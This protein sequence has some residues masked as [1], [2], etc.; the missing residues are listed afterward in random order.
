MKGMQDTM[1]E[2][3]YQMPDTGYRMDT[4]CQPGWSAGHYPVSSI[5]HPASIL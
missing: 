4:G 3:G 5:R 2:E 1:L